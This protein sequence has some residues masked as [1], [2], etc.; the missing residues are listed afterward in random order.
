MK[1]GQKYPL[2]QKLGQKFMNIHKLGTKINAMKNNYTVSH[3]DTQPTNNHYSPLEKYR[4][5]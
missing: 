1:L 5:N 4:K 3:E 2:V